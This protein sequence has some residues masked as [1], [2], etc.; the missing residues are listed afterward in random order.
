M[1]SLELRNE[2]C[3][4]VF[5]HGGRKHGYSLETGDK[6]TAET[7]RGGV[8][9]T[10]MLIGQ[11][12]IAVPEGADVAAFVR[13]GGKAREVARPA[14]APLT[15]GQLAEKYLAAH[16]N[17]AMEAN[18]LGTVRIHLNHFMATLGERFAV[19]SLALADVQGHLDERLKEEAA[20]PGALPGDA[21][22]GGRRLPG[23]VELGGPHGAGRRDVPVQ[24]T[25]LPEDGREAAVHGD[26]R[27][28]EAARAGG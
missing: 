10:L 16:G 27:G 20:R 13:N 7:L 3:R 23:R 11:E 22:H 2:T 14:E 21:P 8:E 28:G 17:G 24:G 4:V 12:A 5:M 19:R 18:S 25:G 9:K 15:L 1:A 26:G 6:Q